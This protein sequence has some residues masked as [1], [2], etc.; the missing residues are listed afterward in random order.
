[1]EKSILDNI[2]DIYNNKS[3]KAIIYINGVNGVGKTYFVKQLFKNRPEYNIIWYN[4]INYNDIIDILSNKN[5]L[6]VSILSYFKNYTIKNIII[7]DDFLYRIQ[8]HK[9]LLNTINQYIKSMNKHIPVIIINN[10][11]TNKKINY[12][13]KYSYIYT[14]PKP[15]Y[16]TLQN[17]ITKHI[18]SIS[19][20]DISKIIDIAKYNLCKLLAII[21]FYKE[22]LIQYTI[23]YNNLM[24]IKNLLTSNPS[25][26]EYYKIIPE[27]ER[28]SLSLIFHEN[29]ILF[30]PNNIVLYST[31]LNN[32]TIA[33]YLDRYIYQKQLWEL[34]EWTNMIK[35]FY[36]NYLIQKTCKINPSNSKVICIFTK[37]LTKYAI[38]YSNKTFIIKLCIEHN[39]K[40]KELIYYV[41]EPSDRLLK[42]YNNS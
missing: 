24:I 29:C 41:K 21:P 2:Q 33:D 22:V 7:I 13:K 12:I 30:F 15:T 8:I 39:C 28:T 37:I 5:S 38:E 40:K 35:L 1:M 4:S 20:I 34:S 25:L 42:L 10:L 26:N 6:K 27:G 17:I 9:I 16:I 11:F 36:S 32:Y 19:N 14:I 31:V 18:P 23:E 3:K